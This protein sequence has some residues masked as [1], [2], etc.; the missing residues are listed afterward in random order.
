[1]E[2]PILYLNARDDE[3]TRPRKAAGIR[4]FARTRGWDVVVFRRLDVTTS[5]VPALLRK[6]RPAGC[7]VEDSCPQPRLPPSLF[8]GIPVV[9]LDPPDRTSRAGRPFVECDQE[10]V[11]AAA[12]RELSD[13]NPPSFAVVPSISLPPW[14]GRRIAEFSRLC[15]AAG[16]P[17]AVFPGRRDEAFA[18]R[19]ARL[20]AWLA[21][22]PA[23]TALFATNDWAAMGVAEAAA[24]LRLR[25]PQDLTLVGVDG[26]PESGADFPIPGVSTVEMDFELAG[27]LAARMLGEALANTNAD[28]A[29]EHATFGPLMVLRRKST[30]GRGRR[31][32]Y[33][34][35]A[36]EMIRREACDGLTAE[37][38]AKRFQ[39]S[40]K[41]FE[42]RF[43]EAVGHGVLDE[44]LHVR[45]Q[46]VLELLGRPEP[47]LSTVSDFCGFG[48]QRELRKL[49]RRRFGCS[50]LEWRRA[51]TT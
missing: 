27:Y 51:R 47:P 23:H 14:N 37:A 49:F 26:T 25:L 21:A 35:E 18:S 29:A 16:R 34:L 8:R 48:T 3:L 46:A 10:A 22:L 2:A 30:G 12:F 19:A 13:G 36:A 45:L 38:L 15:A 39:V 40:R 4:R 44:I 11:A 20:R 50:M 32:P 42:R 41:H 17:C 5:C 43:R 28:N 9:Y 6:H 1:M 24:A 33:I 31:E 7:V